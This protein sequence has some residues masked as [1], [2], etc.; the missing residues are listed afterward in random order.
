MST[1]DAF[2]NETRDSFFNAI[3]DGNVAEVEAAIARTPA[4]LEAED[5]QAKTGPLHL[6]AEGGHVALVDLLLKHMHVDTRDSKGRT[7]LMTAVTKDQ[8]P[9]AMQLVERGADINA[10]NKFGM[11]VIAAA[12][13][14]RSN[15]VRS[16][17]PGAPAVAYLL[18]KGASIDTPA[19]P[20]G[21]TVI[22]FADRLD[23]GEVLEIF[24]EKRPD[25]MKDFKPG[26]HDRPNA[27]DI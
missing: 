12:L 21:E 2:N 1:S 9:T 6:A 10:K 23:D 17:M 3:R 11:S 26:T 5:E 16:G 7:P 19:T 20:R 8:A 25:V 24:R 13:V 27:F 22:Q 18:D 14:L 15:G 4:L